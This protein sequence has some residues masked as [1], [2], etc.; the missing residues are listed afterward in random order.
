MKFWSLFLKTQH[1]PN[2][3]QSEIGS[4]FTHFS[5]AAQAANGV[6]TNVWSAICFK[7]NGH[8]SRDLISFQVPGLGVVSYTFVN[9]NFAWIIQ[10]RTLGTYV[11]NT[12][13]YS[14]TEKPVEEASIHRS[15]VLDVVKRC[16]RQMSRAR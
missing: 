9:P 10:G 7:Q 11:I 2:A 12:I 1:L 16:V 15:H 6:Q 8:W 4:L 3:D 13:S 14:G 5:A